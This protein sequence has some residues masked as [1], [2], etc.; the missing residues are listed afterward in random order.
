MTLPNWLTDIY[1][2]EDKQYSLKQWGDVI[3]NSGFSVDNFIKVNPSTPCPKR[4]LLSAQ[5]HAILMFPKPTRDKILSYSKPESI[6]PVELMQL[7]IN[8]VPVQTREYFWG[9]ASGSFLIGAKEQAVKVLHTIEGDRLYTIRNDTLAKLEQTTINPEIPI[10]MLH[11]PEDGIIYIE[12]GD[13]KPAIKSI[14]LQNPENNYDNDYIDGFYLYEN[15]VTQLELS[16]PISSSGESVREVI[17]NRFGYKNYDSIRSLNFNFEG[18]VTPGSSDIGTGFTF[19][20]LYIPVYKDREISLAE[21]LQKHIDWWHGDKA[22]LEMIGNA[23]LVKRD[24]EIKKSLAYFASLVCLYITSSNYR[25]E[26]YELTEAR[27]RIELSG[28]KKKNNAK[29][30]SLKAVN[31]IYISPGLLDNSQQPDFGSNSN[32]KSFHVRNGHM[33]LQAYGEGRAK[34]KVIW[35]EPMLINAEKGGEIKHKHRKY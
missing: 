7:I 25:E 29:K 22:I 26:F 8:E 13:I 27:K 10:S 19:M 9:E 12:L 34:R 16:N 14:F 31:R 35:V 21:V 18:C 32:K 5:P 24:A 6:T 4:T 15:N 23:E 28:A 30:K 2:F 1:D 20:N 17:E 33:R 3:L 11:S